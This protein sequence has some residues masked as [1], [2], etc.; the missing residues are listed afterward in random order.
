MKTKIPEQSALILD[1]LS[2]FKKR[3]K[4]HYGNRLKYIVLYG[5]YARGDFKKDSDI[6]VLVVL[7]EIKSEINE[8]DV[9]ADLKT[10][11]ILEYEWYLSTNPVDINKFEN[12]NFTFFRNV[13]EDG[14][15][16]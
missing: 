8:I 16:V 7:D 14:V 4:M 15:I 3:A 5:S 2:D 10:D 9:L 6:D 1:F 13:R 12:S 11:I